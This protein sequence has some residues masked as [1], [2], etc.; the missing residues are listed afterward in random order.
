[1]TIR[2]TQIAPFNSIALLQMQMNS[3][4][5]FVFSLLP[6]ISVNQTGNSE[7]NNQYE[8]GKEEKPRSTSLRGTK[9]RSTSRLNEVLMRY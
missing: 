9:P 5:M 2:C 4:V 8:E 1:M 6:R 3:S 7:I